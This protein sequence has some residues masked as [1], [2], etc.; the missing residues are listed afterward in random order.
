MVNQKT[1]DM[2]SE[3]TEG[4]VDTL[5]LTSA[6]KKAREEKGWSIEEVAEKL[7]IAAEHLA[8]MESEQLDIASLDPF[9]RGYLRNYAEVLGVDVFDYQ[10]M[11][12]DIKSIEAPL[13]S[14]SS[15]DPSIKPVFSI[16]TLRVMT[17]IILIALVALLVMINL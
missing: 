8:F 7:K 5:S 15:E 16:A 9:K 3:Q 12:N 1:D 14:V 6:L 13:Q 10:T 17:T 2:V 11:F 4:A